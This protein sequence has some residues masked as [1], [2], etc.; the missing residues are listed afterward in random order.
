MNLDNVAA[1]VTGGASG[2][3]G[4]VSAMIA[5]RGGKV[6]IIDIA[7]QA[8]HA[9]ATTIGGRFVCADITRDEDVEPAL[10]AAERAHGVARVLVNC[11][12]IAT[13]MRT[14]A[15]DGQPHS[16]ALFR[17][18]IDVNLT[19]TFAMISRFASR[20]SAAPLLGE[21]RGV[22]INT[23]SVAGYDGQIGQAAYAA[24]KAGVIGMTLP[25]A[26]DLSQSAIRV[27]TIAPGIFRTPMVS[28]LPQ[29]VQ[30]SLGRQA[31]FPNRLGEPEEFA[32]L[33]GAII[34]NPMLN[35]EVIRLD[36]AIRLPA[37]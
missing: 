1:L 21:E 9:L 14:V 11:A 31:P 5:A 32:A 30:E 37:S 33:V 17:K 6:T 18:A 3:G 24:S 29:A 8:G 4:A 16:M 7:E 34:S 26:R 19:G 27:M 23:A 25:L 22:I 28:G 35:G 2:L 10:A 15:R 20:L 13:G 12:G 36:A